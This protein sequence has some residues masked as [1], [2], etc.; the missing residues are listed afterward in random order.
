MSDTTNDTPDPMLLWSNQSPHQL[1]DE[2][3]AEM[4]KAPFERNAKRAELMVRAAQT[5]ALV[6]LELTIEHRLVPG[7]TNA[8]WEGMRQR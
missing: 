2:A 4:A 3:Q 6:S 7:I 8:I 1:L 5:Q